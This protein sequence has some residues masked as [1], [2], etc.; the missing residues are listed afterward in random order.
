MEHLNEA[1]YSISKGDVQEIMR[2]ELGHDLS[3]Q[4]MT[5]VGDKIGDYIHWHGATLSSI[6]D[7][8]AHTLNESND[9][10]RK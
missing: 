4:E 2:R 1:I 8:I 7:V 10:G 6:E 9:T 5:A 3:E